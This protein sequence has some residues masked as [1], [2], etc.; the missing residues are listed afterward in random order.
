MELNGHHV[1]FKTEHGSNLYGLAHAGSDEDFYTVVS[2]VRNRRA[3]YAKQTIVD[4]IDSMVV[5]LPTWLNMCVSGVPQALEAMFSQ[6][7]IHSEIEPFRAGYVV[8]YGIAER[9][10]RTIKSFTAE[11]DYKKNR[12]GVRLALNL[13]TA[14]REGRFNPTLS[15]D[16]KV[17]IEEL[18]LT[19]PD[20]EQLQQVATGLALD[21]DR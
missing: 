11:P 9:Y 21:L 3:K 10:L 20:V 6:K 18:M 8:S 2:T 17:F 7:V 16:E 5:D 15:D 1:L 12:H 4:G 14:L 13:N 19:Y